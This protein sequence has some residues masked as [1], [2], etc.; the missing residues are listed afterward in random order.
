MELGAVRRHVLPAQAAGGDRELRAPAEHEV[1]GQLRGRPGRPE[2]RPRRSRHPHAGE[3]RHDPPEIDDPRDPLDADPPAP[4]L[5][6]QGDLPPGLLGVP[7]HLRFRLPGVDARRVLQHGPVR[8]RPRR[9]LRAA[10][11][12]QE[13]RVLRDGLPAA[14][15]VPGPDPR[16]AVLRPIEGGEE[17]EGPLHRPADGGA[18]GRPDQP[19]GHH[20]PTG[21]DGRAVRRERNAGPRLAVPARGHRRGDEE[22]A[23]NPTVPEGLQLLQ[24]HLPGGRRR[25]LLDPQGLRHDEGGGR[26]D[27]PEAGEGEA[28]VPARHEGLPVRGLALHL[29]LPRRRHGK[30][31]QS[32]H[33]H[34]QGREDPGAPRLLPPE[35]GPGGREAREGQADDDR[36]GRHPGV[37]GAGRVPLRDGHG[38][39]PV[40][41]Q[42]VPGDPVRGGEVPPQAGGRGQD[43]A[44]GRRV[45]DRPQP[46]VLRVHGQPPA[47]GHVQE[48]EQGRRASRRRRRRLRIGDGNQGD[49]NGGRSQPAESHDR[50]QEG[51]PGQ[52]H[53]R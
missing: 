28:V 5:Q 35:Q 46:W 15:R 45:R 44:R 32:E 24:A 49:G 27:R 4:V 6:K 23:G 37:P 47:A 12:P 8:S 34:A 1:L 9:G 30:L 42:G 13:L 40:H 2:R 53:G 19:H 17:A 10:A 18:G 43:P 7:Q 11:P 26:F 41:R 25:G 16:G 38:P 51:Q 48:R 22:I 20:G 29:L 39:L 21:D 3:V 52:P 36:R 14:E 33:A 50:D 31:P